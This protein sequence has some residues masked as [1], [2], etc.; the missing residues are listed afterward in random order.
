MSSISENVGCSLNWL[1]NDKSKP[2]CANISDVKKT[3]T[4][5]EDVKKHSFEY[6]DKSLGC[7]VPCSNI[8]YKVVDI[9]ETPITWY[10]PWVSEV[11][12]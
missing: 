1:K 5:F 4:Y 3:Q 7:H 6:Y 8:I 9:V 2:S 11:N 10:T 12:Y